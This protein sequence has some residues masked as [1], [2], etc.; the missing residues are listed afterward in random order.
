MF[1]SVR[2]RRRYLRFV[3]AIAV[4]LC[5]LIVVAVSRGATA[6]PQRALEH[7]ADD[8]RERAVDAKRSDHVQFEIRVGRIPVDPKGYL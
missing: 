7:R 2:K 6:P 3:A 5:V 8:I 1:L 4:L